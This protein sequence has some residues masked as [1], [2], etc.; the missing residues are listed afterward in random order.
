MQ[1]LSLDV[2]HS[3]FPLEEKGGGQK[4]RSEVTSNR[5]GHLDAPCYHS[6]RPAG[7]WGEETGVP[8]AS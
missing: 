1:G 4:P 5:L 6:D 7:P 8:G 3:Y 2:S